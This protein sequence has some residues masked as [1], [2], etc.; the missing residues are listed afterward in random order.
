MNVYHWCLV[1]LTRSLAF[2]LLGHL[3]VVIRSVPLRLELSIVH[4][5]MRLLAFPLGFLCWVGAVEAKG[6]LL[7][8]CR[9]PVLFRRYSLLMTYLFVPCCCRVNVSIGGNFNDD[10]GRVLIP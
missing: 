9:P 4:V 7:P 10:C 3:L 6:P 2:P 1:A 8:R 5:T